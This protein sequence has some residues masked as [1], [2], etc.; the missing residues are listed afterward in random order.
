MP[1]HQLFALGDWTPAAAYFVGGGVLTASLILAVEW[2][3]GRTLQR[4]V[5]AGL[6]ASWGVIAAAA[7]LA[8]AEWQLAIV[9]ALWMILTL[10][11]LVPQQAWFER[12][13]RWGLR[14]A[15]VWTIIL[16]GSVQGA[17]AIPWLAHPRCEELASVDESYVFY[18][19]LTGIVAVTDQGREIPL[20]AYALS[21]SIGD[22]ESNLLARQPF[23]AQVIRLFPPS[24]ETNCHGWVFTGGRHAI[25]SQHIEG[26]LSDNLYEPVDSPDVG[27]IVVYHSGETILHTGLVKW[28]DERGTVFV[29]SKWGPLGV[30]LHSALA[31]PYGDEFTYYRTSRPGHLVTI[32]TQPSAD[33]E[34]FVHQGPA[35]AADGAQASADE[36]PDS[37]GRPHQRS[38]AHRARVGRT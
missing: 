37:D 1:I 9:A 5:T 32:R 29:E 22:A 11:A 24:A 20:A 19:E 35:A 23:A 25:P 36:A 27:D 33:I 14:P 15:V 21:S 7:G 28:I 12:T 3:F 26:L 16:M 2:R 13:L 17:I 10:M 4:R 34:S 38:A 31:Q 8:G 30:Y 6:A 18:R